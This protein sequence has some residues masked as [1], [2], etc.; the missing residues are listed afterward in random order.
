[1]AT[2]GIITAAGNGGKLTYQVSPFC[3]GPAQ[4]TFTPLTLRTQAQ[5]SLL[6]STLGSMSSRPSSHDFAW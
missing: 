3:S 2:N 4:R 5:S 6:G 1:M